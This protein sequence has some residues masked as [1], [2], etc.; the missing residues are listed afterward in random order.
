MTVDSNAEAQSLRDKAAAIRAEIA[1]LEG[2]SVEQVEQE[3]QDKKAAIERVAAEAA[4]KRRQEPRFDRGRMVEVPGTWDDMVVQAAR[5]VERAYADGIQRQTVRFALVKQDQ[6]F[7]DMQLW[8][9][10]A[11]EMSREA[12]RPLTRELLKTLRLSKEQ[13]RA[14]EIKEQDV[15]D[16]DGSAIVSSEAP[17]GPQHDVQALVLPNTDAKYI[18]DI[19]T[20]DQN[21]GDRLFLLVNPFW[22]NVDSWGINLLQPGAKKKAQK[23]IFDKGYD[24]TYHFLRFS[25]RGEE[26][27]AIKAYPYDWQIFAFLEDTYTGYEQPIRLGSSKEYPSS[28]EITE[29]LNNRSEFKLSKNMRKMQR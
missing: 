1:A 2:K 27:T 10:G 4:E 18:N 21:I 19:D 5:A 3:A 12:A 22:R 6:S 15:W 14:P 28:E 8:P 13:I 26:C 11:Q 23:V 29:L 7:A 25:V 24:E 16:F 9:G 20:I 17:E